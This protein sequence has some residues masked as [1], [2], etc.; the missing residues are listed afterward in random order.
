MAKSHRKIKAKKESKT[1]K[2]NQINQELGRIQEKLNKIN[3]TIAYL[4]P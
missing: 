1:D 3:G 2:L 4:E